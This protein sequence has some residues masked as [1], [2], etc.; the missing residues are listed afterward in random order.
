MTMVA[1]RLSQLTAHL[2]D[3]YDPVRPPRGIWYTNALGT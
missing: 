3:T 2:L 1:V